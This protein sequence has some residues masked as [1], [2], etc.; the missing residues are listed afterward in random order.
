VRGIYRCSPLRPPVSHRPR[1][2]PPPARTMAALPTLG[3]LLLLHFV[4][5]VLEL[6]I[7]GAPARVRVI[8]GGADGWQART[9]C[10]SRAACGCSCA[11]GATAAG[12]RSSMRSRSS[13]SRRS[14]SCVPFPRACGR[15]LTRAQHVGCSIYARYHGLVVLGGEPLAAVLYLMDSAT[16]PGQV[17]A[18]TYGL[19]AVAIDVMLVRP[20][21]L[22]S[23]P[24]L[25]EG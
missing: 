11:A 12:A 9:A 3:S 10:C 20:S 22:P 6:L 1:P 7:Y 8:G 13:S 5:L 24:P 18:C 2:F 4:A 19:S 25:M 14:P 15:W 21:P 23:P 17:G 16:P